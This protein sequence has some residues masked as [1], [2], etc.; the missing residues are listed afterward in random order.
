V[1]AILAEA[2]ED[3]DLQLMLAAEIRMLAA[4]G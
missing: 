3:V 2:F 1:Q 4:I